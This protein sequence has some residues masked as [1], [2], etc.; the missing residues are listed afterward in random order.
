MKYGFFDD[1]NKE[2][3][4]TEPQ[5]P[6]PWINYFGTDGFFSLCSNTGGGYSFYRDALLRRLTRYRYNDIPADMNGRSFYLK[7]TDGE[8]AGEKWSPA[9][10]PVMRRLDSYECRHG[11]GYTRIKSEL[12]SIDTET[13]FFVPQGSN[14]EIH[15]IR[16]SNKSSRSRKLQFWS[17]IEFCLWNALDDMTNFQRNLNIGEVEVDGGTIYHLTEYRERRNHFSFYSLNRVPDGF[18]TD[19]DSFLGVNRGIDN[20]LCVEQGISR[21]SIA[22]GWFP[23]ASHRVDLELAPGESESLIF[24]LGYV[25]NADDEKWSGSGVNRTAAER[26]IEQFS[27]DDA[28]DK[29]LAG[30]ADFWDAK[31]SRFTVSS[32]DARLDRM[33]NTWNQY[34]CMVT[35]NL[36]RSAS[37]YESGIGRGIGFRDTNQD[38]LGILHM[39]PEKSRRRL[40]DVASIQLPGGGAFHQYQPLTKRGNDAIG[41]DFN[42]DPLWLIIS[43][44]AYIKETGDFSLL[45]EK[46]PF[47]A[48]D[49]NP[50]PSTSDALMVDHLVRA[51]HFIN[52]NRGPHGLPLI[53]RA[54]WNDCLNLNCYSNDPDESFQ[55]VV[56]RDSDTAES[57]FIAAMLVYAGREYSEL[58]RAAGQDSGLDI[59]AA[60]VLS[61][62]ARYA[63]EAAD[64]MEKIILSE[65]WDGE[66]FLRAYDAEGRKVG[67]SENSFGRIFIEPQGFC[68]MAGI[69]AEDGYNLR[70]L[71]SVRSMLATDY[72]INILAPAYRSYDLSKGEITSYPP[73]YKENG[74]IFCHNNP[75]VVIAE[76]VAGRGGHAFE[77]YSRI[78]PAFIED[79]SGLHRTEPYVYAQMIAGGEA[80]NHGQAKNSW[81]TGTAA[82]NYVAASQWILGIR[83]SFQ[84]LVIDPCLP[85]ELKRVEIVR[86]FRGQRYDITIENPEGRSK[87][88]PMLV[89]FDGRPGPRKI[90]FTL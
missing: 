41:G 57:V 64:E 69:G 82:W 59:D 19:R 23:A 22:D 43:V 6:S 78:A 21:D 33:M 51:F 10:K 89:P 36:S 63:A 1:E 77:Y 44:A 79:I 32:G 49:G 81:L 55:T 84:G 31:L 8:H 3:V 90:T 46:V 56:N 25:E 65:G 86:Y 60:A 26:L 70:A 67:S 74:G 13:T 47:A 12:H 71:D 30:L 66:W 85:P 61:G 52:E 42:D 34:Q 5:T 48:A 62:E 72:G 50:D 16:I 58:C 53:G 37:M 20:P 29:A 9:W 76:A 45:A 87:G 40:I 80:S 17:F 35:Y 4:I 39:E 88:A 54:D 38:L 28:V 2:Y 27:T 14:C 75:W 24:V 68:G 11:M 15:R 73:G 18:D 7:D 83:P